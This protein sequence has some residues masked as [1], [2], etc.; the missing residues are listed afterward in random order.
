MPPDNE[1]RATR[2]ALQGA[3]MQVCIY[4]AGAIGSHVA[5]GLLS[6]KS[7]DVSIVALGYDIGAAVNAAEMTA[8]ARAP[9]PGDGHRCDPAARARARRGARGMIAESPMRCIHGMR[10]ARR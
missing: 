2:A 7:A 4:G 3:S 5:A 1:R 8:P 6:A 10:A 9:R